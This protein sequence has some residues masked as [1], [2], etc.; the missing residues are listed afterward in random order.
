MLQ[1]ARFAQQHGADQ[2]VPVFLRRQVVDRAR[3]A[4]AQ[5]VH[6]GRVPQAALVA[7]AAQDGGEVAAVGGELFAADGHGRGGAH[8]GGVR[9]AGVD[10]AEGEDGLFRGG[11]HELFAVRAAADAE[12]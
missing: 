9:V 11:E 7:Y 6:E 4:A 8:Q 5:G 2:P 10:G 1:Q 12:R 3:A